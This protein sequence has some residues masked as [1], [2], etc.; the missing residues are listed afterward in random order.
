M[1]KASDD[2]ITCTFTISGHKTTMSNAKFE[3][4]KFDGTNNFDM[5]Q[6]DVLDVLTQ[7]ELDITDDMLEKDWV[8]LNCQ[9]YGTIR[10]CLA[11]HQQYFVMK[12]ISTKELAKESWD[13]LEN[14]YTSVEN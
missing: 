6:C 14:K 12:E 10:L 9:A 13:K 5:W 8:K 2:K 11:K 4:E 7:Q 1:T 3:M